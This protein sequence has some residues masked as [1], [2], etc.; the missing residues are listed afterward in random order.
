MTALKN[1]PVKRSGHKPPV[2]SPKDADRPAEQGA[3]FPIVGIGAS[4]GGIEAF[5]ALLKELPAD[6]GMAFVIIQHLAPNHENFTSEIL[7]RATRLQIEEVKDNVR[8]EPNHIYVLPPNRSMVISE[9]IL[10]L[11]PRPQTQGL[12]LPINVFFQSLATDQKHRAIGV[13]LSGTASD[14]TRGLEAIKAEGGLT[15]AQEPSS[16]RYDG[17]PSS[18]IASGTVDVVATPGRIALELS[19]IARHPYIHPTTPA[20][21]SHDRE[22]PELERGLQRIFALLRDLL[23]V[24]FSQYKLSTIRRRISRRMVVNKIDDLA[25]Y[26][27]YLQKHPE[28]AKALF[29]DFLIQVTGFFRDPE[30][31]EVLKKIVLPEYMKDREKKAPFRVW[32]PGCS[33]GEEAYSL[34]ILLLEFFS[35]PRPSVPI[36]IFASDISE[37]AIQRARS[38]IYP[39]S[40]AADLSK[41]RLHRFFEP[42]EGGYRIAKVVRDLCLFARHDVITDPPFA[43]LDL[44]SCRNLLIYFT[45][46]LQKHVL[47]IFHYALNPSGI[48]MLGRSETTSAV[49]NLF[50]PADKTNKVY[51]RNNVATPIRVQ[52]P[53]MPYVP[54][55]LS[56]NIVPTKARH[57]HDLMREAD[58]LTLLRYAPAGVVATEDMEI[59]QA[60]GRTS[61]YL[62]LAPGQASLNLFKM[63]RP[64]VL[65]D[66]R[67]AIQ[68]ARKTNSPAKKAGVRLRIDGHE[69]RVDIDVTPMRLAPSAKERYFLI[70]FSETQDVP[71]IIRARQAVIKATKP[72]KESKASAS[73]KDRIIHEL[74]DK[75]GM[76]VEYQQSIVEEY[77]A[78][79]EELTASN[80]ELQSANEELRSTNEELETAK[81]ELQASNEELSTVNDEL[82]NRNAELTLLTND[83]TNLL[84]S[85][86]IP[87]VMVG[88]DARI[89]RF[90]PKAAKALKLIATDVGRPIGDLKPNIDAPDLDKLVFEVMDTLMT[91]EIET[92]DQQ[93]HWYHLQVRPYRTAEKKIDGAV[94]AL[95]DVDALKR[96]VDGLKKARDDATTIIETMPIPLVVLG[97]DRRVHVAN[98]AFYDAFRVKKSDTEGRMLSELGT[99]QWN[100]PGLLDLVDKTL[101]DGTE[102]QGFEVESDFPLIG[103]RIMLLGARKIHLPGAD[104]NGA[105]LSI[106]DFTERRMAVKYLDKAR[107]QAENANRT[108]DE[109]L[110]VLSHELRTPLTTIL[111]WSQLLRMR[112]VDAA[113]AKRGIEMIETSAKAQGQLIDDLL[114]VSRI[115]AGKLWLQLSAVDPVTIGKSVIDGLRASIDGKSIHI[116]AEFEEGLGRLLVD[117]ARFRQILSNLLANAIKFTPSGGHITVSMRRVKTDKKEFIQ[118]QIADTGKGFAPELKQRMFDRFVQGSITSTRTHGGMGLGLSIVKNLVEMHGGTVWAESPG[119]GKGATFTVLLPVKSPDKVS[120]E[121]T[122]ALEPSGID[123]GQNLGTI[124]LDGLRLLVVDDDPGAREAFQTMLTSFGAE[125]KAASSA[126]QALAIFKEFRPHVLLADIAMPDEDGYS[127]IKKVRA[128]G[129]KNGG[130]I[131]AVAVTAY[132]GHDDVKRALAAGYQEHVAK[133]ADAFRLV[134]LIVQLAKKS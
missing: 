56:A 75:L 108:K 103:H 41:E 121:E 81:E 8:V 58:R 117:P 77:E 37:Q 63:T 72:D 129:P 133:P 13:V 5:S 89:R 65:P 92:R 35:A 50:G 28:E 15:F 126:E 97:V 80:E 64:E 36:Q 71:S 84:A 43:K 39:E 27:A 134:N 2:R 78:T 130:A 69:R 70:H 128:F 25:A 46:D 4:A 62:E 11:L 66:L 114:D 99:G 113:A 110:A 86:D 60:R 100:K 122:S 49:A 119:E 57:I 23:H 95:I 107:T 101:T 125:T 10:K 83:M 22:S 87:I 104:V 14:G 20:T 91:K 53:L 17:M 124:N 112:K 85:V 19:R 68:M 42:V 118:T 116:K 98:K 48:L 123:A 115:Q 54:E 94:I 52:L 47:P 34:A 55:N 131:P 120:S 76:A 1:K 102:F 9:G 79:Q 3:G 30:A 26:A 16:A 45:V 90:T 32:V 59:L 88:A 74:R 111:S 29:A 33:T 61:P 109:F 21:E 127:L 24:D 7:S 96:S 132:A 106:E 67:Q 40:I 82:H 73:E 44:I 51:I 12:H 31:F 18:A 105:L 6:T 93:G 38:G